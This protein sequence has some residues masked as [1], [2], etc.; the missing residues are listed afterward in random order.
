MPQIRSKISERS[1]YY[2]SKYRFLELKNFCRQY[3]EWKVEISRISLYGGRSTIR[4]SEIGRP[5][6]NAAIRIEALKRHL[7]AVEQASIAAD[8][9]IYPWILKC[10]TQGIGYDGLDVPCSRD[11]FYDRYRKFFWHLDKIRG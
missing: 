2:I 8:P 3:D 6:E 10:V 1:P 4:G 11:Y 5:V 9:D 7:K